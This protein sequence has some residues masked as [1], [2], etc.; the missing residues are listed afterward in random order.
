ISDRVVVLDY[1][2]KIGDGTPDDVR[3]NEEVISAYLGTSH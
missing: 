1:G 3:N 2:Q